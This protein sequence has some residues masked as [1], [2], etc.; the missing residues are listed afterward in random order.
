MN[1]FIVCGLERSVQ[2]HAQLIGTLSKIPDSFFE[3][4]KGYFASFVK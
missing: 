1:P 2:K 4:W 3:D